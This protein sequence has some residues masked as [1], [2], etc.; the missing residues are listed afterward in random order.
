MVALRSWL[1]DDAPL[2]G[3]LPPTQID[4]R[5]S[6]LQV[7]PA[8]VIGPAD[9]VRSGTAQLGANAQP[10]FLDLSLAPGGPP[11]PFRLAPDR[12]T[13]TTGL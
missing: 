8:T 9:G 13:G 11:L 7:N 1:D 2:Q 10:L 4:V 3:V 5:L 12:R 6:A